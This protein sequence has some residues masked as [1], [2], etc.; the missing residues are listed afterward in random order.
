MTKLNP[1]TLKRTHQFRALT[2]VS[3]KIFD[4]MLVKIRP[5]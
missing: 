1:Q 2:G 5:A 3:S 4:A